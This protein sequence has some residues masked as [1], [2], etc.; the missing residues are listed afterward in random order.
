MYKPRF[1]Q[2]I[3]K[4]KGRGSGFAGIAALLPD[5][6]GDYVHELGN[7]L[8]ARYFHDPSK[9][10]APNGISNQIKD[11][12]TGANLEM[13]VFKRVNFVRLR[14]ITNRGDLTF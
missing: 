10:G 8:A 13:C 6:Q 14:D 5:L 3:L 9:F 12:D 1:P 4:I 2:E 11:Y 7:I